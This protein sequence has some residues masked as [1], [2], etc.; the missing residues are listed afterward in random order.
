LLSLESYQ[1]IHPKILKTGRLTYSIPKKLSNEEIEEYLLKMQESEPLT[2][3]LESLSAE[4]SKEWI[5]NFKGDSTLISSV[6]GE[7]STNRQVVHLQHKSWEGSHNIYDPFTSK[8]AFFYCGFGLNKAQGI[9]PLKFNKIQ[10][11]PK[12]LQEYPE[13]NGEI[14]VEKEEEK[15]KEEEDEE[16]NAQK[17]TEEENKE[18][19]E[20]TEDQDVGDEASNKEESKKDTSPDEE[21]VINE[22]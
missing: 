5:I 10:K 13:P 17:E 22:D 2:S 7:N 3:P 20:Q 6:N 1:T 21:N 15:S 9:Y 4:S 11:S 8:W 18:D 14:V 19:S 16:G 12:D